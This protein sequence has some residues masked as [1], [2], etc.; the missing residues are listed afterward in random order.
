ME[1]ED[2]IIDLL[3]EEDL[4]IL[5]S[6]EVLRNIESAFLEQLNLNLNSQNKTRGELN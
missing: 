1:I 2:K 4:D 6:I 5:E 3:K